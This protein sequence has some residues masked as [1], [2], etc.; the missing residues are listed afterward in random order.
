MFMFFYTVLLM[1]YILEKI[2]NRT[3][4]FW[5][6]IFSNQEELEHL[7]FLQLFGF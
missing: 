7:L 3:K 4:L 5:C 6:W 2:Y 1:Q